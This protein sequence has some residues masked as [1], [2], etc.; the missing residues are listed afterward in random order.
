MPFIG[1]NERSYIVNWAN[2]K[3]IQNTPRFSFYPY[4]SNVMFINSIP[5]SSD[6][7]VSGS[8]HFFLINIIMNSNSMCDTWLLIGFNHADV[9][10]AQPVFAIM[11]EGND[12]RFDI[13]TFPRC[14]SYHWFLKTKLIN[15]TLNI[16][17]LCT[18]PHINF[19]MDIYPFVSHHN[20]V[21][22]LPL[23]PDVGLV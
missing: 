10:C 16:D 21:T 8:L 15:Q 5:L 12:K 13:H 1:H 4:W 23:Q 14:I 7:Y 2:V 18:Y 3:C 11:N 6:K 17:H 19:M 9:R 20:E 22:N